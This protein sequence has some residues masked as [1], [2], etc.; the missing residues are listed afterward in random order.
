MSISSRRSVA[1]T[2]LVSNWKIGTK[3]DLGAAHRP[4]PDALS[5]TCADNVKQDAQVGTTCCRQRLAHVLWL[6]D[7]LP[8]GK[9]EEQQHC[10][11]SIPQSCKLRR[12]FGHTYIEHVTDTKLLDTAQSSP[13][14]HALKDIY[15]MHAVVAVA[16][17]ERPTILVTE[18]L[19]DPGALPLPT[20]SCPDIP[21]TLLLR[22]LRT[23]HSA[24]AVEQSQRLMF[25]QIS[26]PKECSM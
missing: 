26:G 13:E 1:F 25:Q 10:Q 23:C 9:Q 4:I 3:C 11:V 17:S 12:D 22:A 16:A 21:C 15:C 7:N 20:A 14:R 5:Y 18:K 24:S 2:H 8:L 6:S 19:G